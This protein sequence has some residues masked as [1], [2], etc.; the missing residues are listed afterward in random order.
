MS[1]R[2]YFVSD[3]PLWM[4]EERLSRKV[5]G[6]RGE[7]HSMGWRRTSLRPCSCFQREGKQKERKGD[8]SQGRGGGG[9]DQ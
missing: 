3:S 8:P 9:R 2:Q 6:R 1:D 5:S 7:K 4:R